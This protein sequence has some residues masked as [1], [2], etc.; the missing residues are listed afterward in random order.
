MT[1]HNFHL[2]ERSPWPLIGSFRAFIITSRLINFIHFNNKI[3]LTLRLIA[4]IL[5]IKQWW[6]DISREATLQGYHT[7]IVK[8]GLKW[9]IILFI[10]REIL[11]FFS[12]FWAFFHRSLSP[13]TELGINWPPTGVTPFNPYHI[14]LLNTTILL[15]SGVTITWS[16]HR[17]LRKNYT[18]AHIRLTI[19]ILLGLYF[20]ALQ[21]FEYIEA[22][23]TLTDRVYGTTFF[24]ATGFHGLH[25]LIGTTFLIVNLTRII[26]NH[27]SSLHHFSFE[28]AAWYWHFVDVVWLFLY[29]FVY[30]WSFYFVS[31]NS[32][33]NF[34]LKSSKLNKIIIFITLIVLITTAIIAISFFFRKKTF[35][36]KEKT[37]PFECGFDPAIKTRTPFSLRFFK[38]SIIFIIF[39]IEIILILPIPI[40][41]NYINTIYTSSRNLII[42]IILFG[43]LYEWNQGRLDW[44]K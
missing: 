40:T 36:D 13:D 32:T 27:F 22:P 15:A 8:K 19:T 1:F 28:A 17:I 37:T 31:I 18:Q 2:V 44:V 33:F 26:N 3:I 38:I 11:F 41:K 23:F 5:V 9:G 14:P 25:V 16:H 35:T 30:W 20:S 24:V 34:Q 6:R 21:A 42:L 39:D 43:L 4:T 12:F 7:L 29:T 10:L